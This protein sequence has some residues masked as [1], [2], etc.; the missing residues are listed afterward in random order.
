M[1]QMSVPLL[2]L[3]PSFTPE[4]RAAILDE[5]AQ[6][7]DEQ[8]FI[9]GPRVA[10]FEAELAEY[11][12]SRHSIGVSSG[13]DA[14]LLLLMAMGIGRGDA[15]LTTPYTFFATAGCIHRV[16]ALPVFVDIEPASFN[17]SVAAVERYLR[18]TAARDGEGHLRT[19]SGERLRAIAPV[20]LY[21]QC[22]D[23]EALN[24]LGAEFG[25]PVLEDAAQALG[26][27]F[28]DSRGVAKKAGNLGY[29]SWYSFY[30]TKNLGGFGDAG[31]CAYSDDALDAL[32]RAYRNHG[33][34][35]LYKHAHVGGNFR[36]DALQA[37]ALRLKL[38]LLDGW[39]DQRR[40][41]AG[42]YRE[43]FAAAGIGEDVVTLPPALWS[44]REVGNA[45]RTH[46]YNQFVI[47]AK[48]RD[49][50]RERLT[51]EGVGTQIYYPIPLHRQECFA[52]LGYNEGDF[53][54]AELAAAESLALPVFPGLTEAQ[55]EYVVGV[56]RSYY[57]G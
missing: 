24:A 42:M 13:T 6:I 44:D 33:Q 29:A 17:I 22:A 51:R 25:L 27:D 5:M 52:Y 37:A 18:E 55:I 7:A 57:G 46:I 28:V 14:Q 48:D 12:G 31:A 34:T 54:E 36:L 4:L 43:A 47:R 11:A 2:D 19:P 10:A 35:A 20:H 21:G 41:A 45:A 56:V 53:P 50:L 49:G 40:Q 38:P 15:V 39:C 1:T 26:A 9:L 23:M 32:M 8:G 3:R 16:G 30:P